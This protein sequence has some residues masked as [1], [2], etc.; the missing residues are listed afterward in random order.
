M[1][2]VQLVTTIVTVLVDMPALFET[3]SWTVKL[4]L[5]WYW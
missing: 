2:H 4:P 5:F 3:T 1:R